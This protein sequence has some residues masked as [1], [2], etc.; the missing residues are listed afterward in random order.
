MYSV[1]VADDNAVWLEALEEGLNHEE[2][3]AVV[4]SANNGK[5][6]LELIETLR[7]DVM[8]LDIIMP[9]CDGVF[10][11][12]YIRQHMAGYQPIIYM[13]SGIGSDAVITILNQL[14]I[15]FYSMKPLSLQLIIENL[16]KILQH[17]TKNLPASSRHAAFS[18]DQLIQDFL[19][20]LGLPP[21]LLCTKYIFQALE[22]YR[23]DPESF[24]MLTKS[25]YPYIAKRNQNTSGAVEKNIRFA[26]KH[27][28]A[29]NTA[30]YRQVFRFY[31]NKKITNSIFLN[32]ISAYADSL[33]EK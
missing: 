6:A 31:Q 13:L 10:I 16:K 2:E 23:E 15:D 25:L 32:V 22:Y 33:L 9:E 8:I 30:L 20:D 28:Q 4:A 24:G 21:H 7:P 19:T 5:I 26:I 14:D 11:V 17:R 1:L 12:N 3:F 27:I 18:R 29:E